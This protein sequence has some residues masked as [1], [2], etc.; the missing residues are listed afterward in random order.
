MSK[1][2]LLVQTAS[3]SR[4]LRL[5]RAH[6]NMALGVQA[7][8]ALPAALDIAHSRGQRKQARVA[9]APVK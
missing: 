1:D 5:A 7:I 4:I 9:Q 6:R 8:P 2:I 3:A